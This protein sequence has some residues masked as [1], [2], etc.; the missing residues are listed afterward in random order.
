MRVLG[1][2]AESLGVRVWGSAFTRTP[3]YPDVG[4]MSM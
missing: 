4:P 2:R 3:N 1:S